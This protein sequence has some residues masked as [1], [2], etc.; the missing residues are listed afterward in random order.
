VEVAGR[1]GLLGAAFLG[2]RS[3]QVPRWA[4][5]HLVA[6]GAASALVTFSI[7][8]FFWE[9]LPRLRFVQLPWR[10]LLCRNVPLSLFVTMAFRRWPTRLLVCAAMFA[11]V[12]GEIGRASCRER[13]EMSVGEVV[14]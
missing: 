11:V 9:H 10:W 12:V 1:V 14:S 7:T 13:L 3:R 6:W 4:R 2:L 8:F 5:W